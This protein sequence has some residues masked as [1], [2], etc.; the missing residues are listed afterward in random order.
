[1][2]Y[3]RNSKISAPV[4]ACLGLIILLLS[5]LSITAQEEIRYSLND[6]VLVTVTPESATLLIV[7]TDTTGAVI[8]ITARAVDN[9][10]LD[11]VL[12]ITDSDSRLLAYNH[13]TLTDEGLVD[14]SARIDN[15]ILPTTGLYSIY[16]DSFNGVQTGEVTV[17]IRETNLFDMQVEELDA[18]E[19][20]TF[21]L[22]EDSV[23]S[24]TVT[25]T[26]GDILTVTAFDGNGQLDPY[27]RIVD[28]SGNII[29]ANDDHHTPD[30]TLN[31]FDARIAEWQV[32]ADD[33]YA[34]EVL[35][36]LGRAGVMTLEIR[37][38]R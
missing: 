18:M 9:T 1:M 25:A 33:T 5:V 30:L 17:T 27:L 34:I 16:V 36:F 4:V 8:T 26:S 10:Q 21:S 2:C 14:V 20:V 37:E 31:T 23:F 13:N 3:F 19:L 15:L 12:W 35:D 22:R 38:Q 28:S 6:E 29:M 7:E 32:P 11:P 24:Y